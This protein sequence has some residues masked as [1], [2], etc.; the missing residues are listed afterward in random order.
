MALVVLWQCF[1][2]LVMDPCPIVLG[3]VQ[4]DNKKGSALKILQ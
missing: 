2:A 3:A 4:T 1:G